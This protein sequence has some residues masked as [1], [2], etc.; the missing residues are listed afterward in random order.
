MAPEL[1]QLLS[2]QLHC[3]AW[4]PTIK[5]ASL[6]SGTDNSTWVLKSL[7]SVLSDYFGAWLNI[8][9]TM[10]VEKDP[11]KRAFITANHSPKLLFDDLSVLT[12]ETAFDYMSQ[13]WVRV[14]DDISIIISGFPCQSVSTR[15]CKRK[16]NTNCVR[17]GTA[18]T[19]F[20]NSLWSCSDS[21]HCCFGL[22]SWT[23]S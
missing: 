6:C 23:D 2:D 20:Q 18:T 17:E 15:N 8:E 11:W 1:L 4:Q 7:E 12:D 10:C 9:H 16:M 13:R 21:G 19:G 5:L 14:P 22:L 3:M